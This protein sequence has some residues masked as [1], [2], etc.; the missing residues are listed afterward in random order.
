MRVVGVIDLAGGRAVHA[1]GGV[2]REYQP[3]E[4]AGGAHV[5]GDAVSLARFYRDV[6]GLDDIYVA[7]LDAISGEPANRSTLTRLSDECRRLWV[8]AGVGSADAAQSVLDAGASRVIIGLETLPDYSA[9]D[10]MCRTLRADSM[11]LSID[12]RDGRLVCP[13]GSPMAG[14]SIEQLALRAWQAGVR[15]LIVL[16]LGR[17]GRGEGPGLIDIV[18]V[19][20]A[21]PDAD[22]YAG[23]GIRSRADVEDLRG[24]GVTGVL[25]ATAL[26]EGRLRPDEVHEILT[27]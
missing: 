11:V 27:R 21:V 17:V 13:P 1:R 12:L 9:L 14:Q 25:L 4:R 22:V 2:R 23:G 5:G 6:C 10:E 16:E 19:R 20:N 18:A 3:V 15:T 8:D 7:D 26:C 24:V